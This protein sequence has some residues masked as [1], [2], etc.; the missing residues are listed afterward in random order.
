VHT[1]V[2]DLWRPFEMIVRGHRVPLR[3]AEWRLMLHLARPPGQTRTWDELYRVAQGSHIFMEP[4]QL[5]AHF[6]RIRA[7][8]REICRDDHAA[9][10]LRTV[11]RMGMLLDLDPGAVTVAG[12]LAWSRPPRYL[13]D[14]YGRFKSA[15]RA[16]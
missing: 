5:Y 7:K 16:R 3:P 2:L 14:R 11:P 4:G 8:T 15:V 9:D 12:G 6:C 10:F 1:L 13:R